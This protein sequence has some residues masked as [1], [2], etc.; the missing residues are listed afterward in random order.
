MTVCDITN[1]AAINCNNVTNNTSITISGTTVT[2]K[3][4]STGG[5]KTTTGTVRAGDTLRFLYAPGVGG[6]FYRAPQISINDR[7]STIAQ[8][9]Y[10]K[11][12]FSEHWQQSIF[13]GIGGVAN[14]GITFKY[15]LM[16][17]T[18]WGAFTGAHGDVV[19]LYCGTV[20]GVGA[21]CSFQTLT[22][23]YNTVIQNDANSPTTTTTFSLLGSGTYGGTATTVNVRN[24]VGIYPV[25]GRVNTS[26]NGLG[27]LNPSWVSTAMNISNNYIDPTSAGS[28]GGKYGARYWFS[29]YIGNA[30]G[31]G[32]F[33]T[34]PCTS[35][36]NVNL[37]TG[38]SLG[39]APGGY[40][41]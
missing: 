20:N 29:I 26:T 4:A 39:A 36:G 40:C 25:A 21:S 33:T 13:A 1:D 15:N 17:N 2:L 35:T 6:S 14:T 30:G 24:N 19:Q 37:K 12:T 34:T 8:H 18:G 28:G 38:G 27:V 16:E 31:R 11:D 23:D 32:P 3:N 10:F 9:N 5:S 7:G 41:H 22:Y